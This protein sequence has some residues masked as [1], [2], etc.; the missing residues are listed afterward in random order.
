VVFGVHSDLHVIADNARAAPAGRHRTRVGI[1][2]RNLLI[3]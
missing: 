1:G 3:R 2:Q